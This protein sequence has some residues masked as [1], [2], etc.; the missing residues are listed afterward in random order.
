[1]GVKGLW[2]LLSVV[3]RRIAIETL[4]SIHIECVVFFLSIKYTATVLF[5]FCREKVLAVDISIW[6]V[7]FIKVFSTVPFR[8]HR[9]YYV[10]AQIYGHPRCFDRPCETPVAESNAML[11]S[12]GHSEE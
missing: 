6:L 4:R 10:F 11:T 8:S 3:G 9:M 2:R 5:F 1:M 7:Q 12:L